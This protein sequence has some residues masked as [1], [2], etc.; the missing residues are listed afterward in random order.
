MKN[1]ILIIIYCIF[2]SIIIPTLTYFALNKNFSE[3]KDSSTIY[4]KVLNV[5]NQ[6]ITLL[7]LEEYVWRA[8]AKEMPIS[9]ERDAIK[10]QA[11]AIRTYAVR[12]MD[13]KIS[14]HNGADVCTDFAHCTAFSNSSEEK[15]Y[16]SKNITAYKNL[17]AE[18]EGEILAYENEP[19]LAVFHSISSG[20]TEKSSDVWSS[21][22]PYLTNVNSEP[23]VNVTGYHSIASF[24][25]Q[26]L[27]KV[28]GKAKD[29]EIK[30]TSR[31][32]AGSV[33]EINV[34]GLT[35]S[36]QDIRNKLNL[37][38]A[39]FHI[40]K[41]NNTYIFDVYGYGHGVGMSQHGANEYAKLGVNYEDILKKYYPSTTLIDLKNLNFAD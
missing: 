24:S 36:G 11:V 40:K 2:L 38:S 1:A 13:S 27:E 30:I 29:S 35:Y 28:F 14:V 17:C 25:I 41:E 33:K 4:I 8:T 31:T 37:R 12:K 26:D 32:A 6:N 9:F 22:L 7:P 18:T 39:N 21:Q 16:S 19:I 20:T 3:K 34:F 23:D 5:E 15:K 10:A